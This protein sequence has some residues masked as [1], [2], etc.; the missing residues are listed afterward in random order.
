MPPH[1]T[2]PFRPTQY[3]SAKRTTHHRT[4]LR[5]AVYAAQRL[6]HLYTPHLV[7]LRKNAKVAEVK[8][9]KVADAK[10]AKQQAVA[11][12]QKAATAVVTSRSPDGETS[13][14]SKAKAKGSLRRRTADQGRDGERTAAELDEAGRDLS[15]ESHRPGQPRQRRRD[16]DAADEDK[17]P[18]SGRGDGRGEAGEQAGEQKGQGQCGDGLKSRGRATNANCSRHADGKQLSKGDSLGFLE[19]VS[20]EEDE[21]EERVEAPIPPAQPLSAVGNLEGHMAE[22]QGGA[23]SSALGKGVTSEDKM[24]IKS[25]GDEEEMW[26]EHA[27]VRQLI[28]S[29]HITG[30]SHSF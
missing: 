23:A 7:C 28:G 20:S 25:V 29:T 2:L 18:A 12:K 16:G 1:G 15:N 24:E 6:G 4:P 22:G 27:E 30:S 3:V 14:L 13:L 9:A 11:A 19:H 5:A 26:G 17:R 21:L 10:V 8:A